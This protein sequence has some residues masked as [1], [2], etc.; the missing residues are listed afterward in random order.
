MDKFTI[1]RNCVSPA[2]F[3]PIQIRVSTYEML[4]QILDGGKCAADTAV[5]GNDAV[6]ERYIEIAPNKN[7]LAAYVDILN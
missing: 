1:K 5:V 6:L 7:L 3:K 2:A 4:K